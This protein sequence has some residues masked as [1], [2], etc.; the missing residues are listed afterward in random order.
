M[1]SIKQFTG[2]FSLF[3]AIIS[4]AV[5]AQGY[6]GDTWQNTLSSGSGTLSVVYYHTPGIIFKD[7]NGNMSGVCV[8]LLEDFKQFL[9]TKHEVKVNIKYL[10]EEKVWTKFLESIK[11]SKGGIVGV[12]NTTITAQ[13]LKSFD[14]SPSYLSNPMVLLTHKDAPSIKSMEEIGTKF[15]GFT[16]QMI[17]GSTHIEYMTAIKK[18]YYPDM[19]ISYATS[20]GK[21]LQAMST[22][23]TIFS[24]L[25]FSEYYDAVKRRLPIKKHPVNVGKTNEKLGLIM[26]KQ[27]DWSPLWREFLSEKYKKSARYRQIIT[28]NLGGQFT[29]LID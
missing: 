6:S 4:S 16:A 9:A 21:I 5:L 24:I 7:K 3:F 12:A 10:K 19:Q 28:E 27:N 29:F 1:S 23:K 2:L 25:D 20:G 26:P 18:M 8:A 11:K 22:N 14:F 17:D 13:R 15:K